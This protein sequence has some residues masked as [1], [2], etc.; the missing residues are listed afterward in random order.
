MSLSKP[1]TFLELKT[2]ITL[3]D[4]LKLMRSSK[5]SLV[6]DVMEDEDVQFCWTMIA[7]DIDREEDAQELL[8][9]IVELWLTIRG[10]ST[11]AV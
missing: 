8:Q 11:T 10:F 5:Q 9:N 2:R 4:H 1:T 7:V 6:C 3:P